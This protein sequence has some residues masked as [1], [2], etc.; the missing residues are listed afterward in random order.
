MRHARVRFWFSLWP[1][2]IAVWM[3]QYFFQKIWE[4]WNFTNILCSYS[5]VTEA[6]EFI[7]SIKS[8]RA[9]FLTVADQLLSGRICI[10]SMSMGGAKAS[11]AIA[12]RWVYQGPCLCNDSKTFHQM[13]YD[14]ICGHFWW[15]PVQYSF[16]QWFLD[17]SPTALEPFRI[18]LMRCDKNCTSFELYISRSF[19]TVFQSLFLG[20]QPRG[21]R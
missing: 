7:T 10:A 15:D 9:R 6:G 3:K 8:P 17:T 14:F 11:L 4:I 2:C 1:G 19:K 18:H 20:I 12:L 13:K 5:D 21:W 16:R